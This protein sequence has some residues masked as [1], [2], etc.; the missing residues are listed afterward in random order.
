MLLEF[1]VL[2]VLVSAQLETHDFT[3]FVLEVRVVK[4]QSNIND[5]A[6]HI[7]RIHCVESLRIVVEVNRSR[8]S[9]NDTF[10]ELTFRCFIFASVI[11]Q[12]LDDFIRLVSCRP[13]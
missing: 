5:L 8:L 13:P 7:F 2:H 1:L 12:L 4:V 3:S 11:E 10:L 9:Q 6:S